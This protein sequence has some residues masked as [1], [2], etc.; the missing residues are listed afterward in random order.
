[1]TKLKPLID[2]KPRHG[3]KLDEII[4]RLKER[5]TWSTPRL[6]DLKSLKIDD[7]CMRNLAAV[8]GQCR[9]L[10]H[11]DLGRNEIGAEG[12]GLLA[13]V[14]PQC[15]SLAHLHLGY[16]NIGAE[17]AG[18]LAAV[19]PRCPSL[20]HLDLG[21]NQIGAEGARGLRAAALPS[22]DLTLYF[23]LL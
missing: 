17:G 20:A 19:L 14:L 1:M 12:A 2:T 13:P 11:L 3:I 4:E 18:R 21:D 5:N 16:N 10:A 8:L 6:L 22:L 7:K 15:P 23:Q 9:S